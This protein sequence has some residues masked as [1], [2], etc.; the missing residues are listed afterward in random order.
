VRGNTVKRLVSALRHYGAKEIHLRS[1]SPPLRYPCYFG[2]DIPREKELIAAG[3]T[4]EEVRQYIGVDSL[5]YLSPT[6]LGRAINTA[7]S[8]NEIPNDKQAL[9]MLHSEFCYG[10]MET[11]GWPFDP[12]A[13]AK[14]GAQLVN[15]IPRRVAVKGQ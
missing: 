14:H 13:E 7:M 12:K 4:V 1:A 10:C 6:G 5:G 8:A 2:I 15:L 11:Q 3:R 9:Q